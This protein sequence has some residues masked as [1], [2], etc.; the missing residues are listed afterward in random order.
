MVMVGAPI[1][2]ATIPDLQVNAVRLSPQGHNRTETSLAERASSCWAS[3]SSER[4][5]LAL[6]SFSTQTHIFVGVDP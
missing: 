5:M 4:L 1:I 3:F 2:L 6:G